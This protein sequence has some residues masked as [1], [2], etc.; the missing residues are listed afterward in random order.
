MSKKLTPT[1][2]AILSHALAQTQGKVLWFPETLK[3]GAKAK[4]IESLVSHGLISQKKRETVVTKAGYEAL[5]LKPP[6]VE[7][8]T[9]RT[10]ETSKQ[11]TV[12]NSPLIGAFLDHLERDRKSS[13]RTRN[14]RLAAIRSL[15][16]Y[17]ALRHP[18]HAATIDRVLAIPPKR[19]ER[20][21]VTS[22]S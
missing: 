14:A 8:R 13:V 4:A 5:G 19:F 16:R 11:A 9:V 18:E 20:R 21:L 1:Q 12:I 15:F 6:V 2:H 10:R 22:L 17:A 7:P 3:G